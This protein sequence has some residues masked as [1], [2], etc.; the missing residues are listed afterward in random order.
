MNR[1]K[2]D[3][4]KSTIEIIDGHNFSYQRRYVNLDEIEKDSRYQRATSRDWVKLLFNNWCKDLVED[5][6]V[7]KRNGK[8]YCLD[9]FHSVEAMR[10]RGIKKCWARV[11]EEMSPQ[12]EALRFAALNKQRK[13]MTNVDV[14]KAQLF[15]RE[16]I[17]QSINSILKR[18]GLYVGNH[19]RGNG[20]SVAAVKTL[21]DIHGK[22]GPTT[23]ERIIHIITTTWSERE[24]RRV[25]NIIFRG[26]QF[27]YSQKRYDKID[28]K[29]LITKLK[30]VSPDEIIRKA[31]SIKEED[32]RFI[33]SSAAARVILQ[34][35][36]RGLT[37][38][39][40]LLPLTE[41]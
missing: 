13:S 7:S 30:E 24:Q 41:R 37:R 15:G 40:L 4:M 5:I 33:A 26:L 8:L 17:A 9:G 31:R 1:G 10:Q 38:N 14:F 16:P 36:N 12:D 32:P 19:M 20:C 21:L 11:F 34:Y 3:M 6:V 39:R 2:I 29:R 28:D 18:C 35:Y 25:S 23:L 22:N 27:I